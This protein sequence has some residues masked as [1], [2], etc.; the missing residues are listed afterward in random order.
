MRPIYLKAVNLVSIFST[1]LLVVFGILWDKVMIKVIHQLLQP[2]PAITPYLH[3]SHF[4]ERSER[5]DIEGK[6]GDTAAIYMLQ[7]GDIIC[8]HKEWVSHSNRQHF[9]YQTCTYISNQYLLSV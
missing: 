2:I 9:H 1:V 6:Y 4:I 5:E 7:E 3:R 8:A